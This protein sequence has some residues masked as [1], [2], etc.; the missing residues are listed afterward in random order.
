MSSSPWSLRVFLHSFQTKQLFRLSHH[1][2]PPLVAIEVIV[3]THHNRQS[4]NRQIRQKLIFIFPAFFSP[5]PSPHV[6]PFFA[7]WS[8]STG[9]HTDET[10]DFVMAVGFLIDN[11]SKKSLRKEKLIAVCL[12]GDGVTSSDFI[13]SWSSVAFNFLPFP[14]SSPPPLIQAFLLAF[15]H[16]RS[17]ASVRGNTS[18][19]ILHSPSSSPFIISCNNNRITPLWRD[20][21]SCACVC[22]SL[23]S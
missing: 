22:V 21:L 18:D 11:I 6:L 2:H 16:S 12:I 19:C 20:V 9:V 5:S 1:R 15:V 14:P 23:I 3:P 8:D 13:S 17:V 7:V 10:L 4:T